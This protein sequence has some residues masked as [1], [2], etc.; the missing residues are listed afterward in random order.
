MVN[1]STNKLSNNSFIG[2]FSSIASFEYERVPTTAI[3]GIVGF[4]LT[5]MAYDLATPAVKSFVL[6]TLPTHQHNAVLATSTVLQGLGGTAVTLIGVCDLPA[7]V[8]Y[9]FK[10]DG[11]AGTLLLLCGILVLTL[12]ISFSI[13]LISG[14]VI[15]RWMAKR[16]PS[17]SKGYRGEDLTKS[18][19][20]VE[21]HEQV[22]YR[23]L[24]TSS[25]ESCAL[26][27]SYANRGE[28]LYFSQETQDQQH[29]GPMS[30]KKKILSNFSCSDEK[31]CLLSYGDHRNVS[32]CSLGGNQHSEIQ[33]TKSIWT[34]TS[35]GSH[36]SGHNL[37]ESVSAAVFHGDTRATKRILRNKRVITTCISCFFANG[38]LL[39]F[40]IYS[41]NALTIGIYKGDPL[42]LPGLPGRELYEKGM[43]LGAVGILL[44]YTS[45]F[46]SSMCNHK[47]M[48]MLGKKLSLSFFSSYGKLKCV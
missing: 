33:E 36:L 20:E 18:S 26:S 19:F 35:I 13:T 29:E 37:C 14:K 44:M 15:G 1:S 34:Q 16:N 7:I 12:I 38:C 21:Q 10:V 28:S 41:P 42:A 40:S 43:R 9:T 27:L 5:D 6:D 24:S 25:T 2:N 47:M 23:P 22:K 39:C 31:Q 48:R 4:G 32:Q 45:T 46:I 17:K 3:L 8:G 30:F 11:I